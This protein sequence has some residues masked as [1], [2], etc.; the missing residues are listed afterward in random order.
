MTEGTGW[1]EDR[2]VTTL[3][4]DCYGTLVDWERGGCAALR[5]LL[6]VETPSISDDDLIEEFLD[7]DGRLIGRPPHMLAPT[8]LLMSSNYSVDKSDVS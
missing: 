3:T 6:P 4:F 2:K 1:L 8:A 5:G 7:A